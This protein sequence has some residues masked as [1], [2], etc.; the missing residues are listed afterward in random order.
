MI[1]TPTITYTLLQCMHY[2]ST[3]QHESQVPRLPTPDSVHSQASNKQVKLILV[4][5]Q[6]QDNTNQNAALPAI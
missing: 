2:S 3:S 5:E 6:T 1:L 4:Q